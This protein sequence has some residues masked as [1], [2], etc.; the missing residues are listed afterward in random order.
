M[1]KVLGD[2]TGRYYNTRNSDVSRS[3][4]PHRLGGGDVT[5]QTKMW[6]SPG[7]LTLM[8][9][10]LHGVPL[11]ANIWFTPHLLW[12]RK[13]GTVL[14]MINFIFIVCYITGNPSILGL[15]RKRAVMTVCE[16]R[17]FRFT[18][19][20]YICRCMECAQIIKCH[21][22]HSHQRCPQFLFCLLFS[23]RWA[24]TLQDT[25]SLIPK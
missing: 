14:L 18:L 24:R 2:V 15:N 17:Y 11:Y 6:A 9:R 5:F 22:N 20:M 13:T 4:W 7:K 23:S 25:G 19:L 10:R 21:I 1:H 12:E 16:K 8:L 3:L